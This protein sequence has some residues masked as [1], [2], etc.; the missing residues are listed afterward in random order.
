MVISID[1][2]GTLNVSDKPFFASAIVS[3]PMASFDL[4]N[5]CAGA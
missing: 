5:L 4:G 2:G 1:S 3:G